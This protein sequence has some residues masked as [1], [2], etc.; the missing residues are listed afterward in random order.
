MGKYCCHS[1]GKIIWVGELD[2]SVKVQGSLKIPEPLDQMDEVSFMR[3]F[4][5]EEEQIVPKVIKKDHSKIKLAVIAVWEIPCGIATY[6]KFLTNKMF[7][8]VGEYKVFC[9]KNDAVMASENILPCWSRG[10]PLG[11]LAAAVKEYRPDVVLIQHEYGLFPDARYWLALLYQLHE[12]KVFVTFHSIFHHQDKVICEAA[13]PNIIVHSEIARDLLRKEKKLSQ[14][15]HVIPHGCHLS[16]KLSRLWNLYQ[17]D[18]TFM[19]FGFGFEYKGWE[20]AIK[21]LALLKPRYPKA[22][23]TGIFSESPQHDHLPYFE[24]LSDLSKKLGVANSMTILRGFQAEEVLESFFRTNKVAV[25][26][27]VAHP[28][29][30]V[31][32][33]TG[34][35]RFA[36]QYDIPVIT[37]EVPLFYDLKGVC[38]QINSPEDLAHQIEKMWKDPRE[39][40]KRQQEYMERTS[41]ENVADQYLNVMNPKDVN[42]T[43]KL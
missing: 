34:A 25:F 6:T 20:L 29:H 19:Q 38:P 18:F 33:V 3:N 7:P 9:E 13:A 4:K 15:I 40:V 42:L 21:A 14:P 41:W 27:Y 37:S 36:M 8:M 28:Q 5:V 16:K 10:E 26:P 17:S 31:Y 35:A 11:D 39:Q 22:F 23:F 2:K 32:G 30:V 24:R 12:L 43:E 1:E